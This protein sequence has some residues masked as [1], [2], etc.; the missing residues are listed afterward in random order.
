MCIST[1]STRRSATSAAELRVAA[2]GRDVVDDRRAG[3]ESRRRD[4]GLR[5]V[6]RDRGGGLRLAQARDHA[7]HAAQLLGHRHRLGAGARRLAPHV[8]DLRA[9]EHEPAAVLDRALVV[10]VAPA[11]GERVGSITV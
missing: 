6:D 5:G 10:E 1:Q 4:R 7:D 8:D 2:Q 9:L 3:V 11:V